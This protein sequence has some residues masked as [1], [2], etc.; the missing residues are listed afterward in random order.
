[1]ATILCIDD[2]PTHCRLLARLLQGEQHRV[3]QSS[4]LRSGLDTLQR[5]PD[6]DLI[7][8]DLHMPEFT[9]FDALEILKRD[10]VTQSIPV[11]VISASSDP[12]DES[13]ARE[14]GAADY[15]GYP[16]SDERIIAAVRRILGP[17]AATA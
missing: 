6:V 3:L 11:L 7:L 14:M 10:P 17:K 16:T 15:V 4:N 2:D 5:N 9:G 12:K 8:L 1:M 13:R